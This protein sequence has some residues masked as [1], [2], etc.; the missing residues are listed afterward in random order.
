MSRKY[1][2]SSLTF[3]NLGLGLKYL[4]ID[5]ERKHTKS[6]PIG[7]KRFVKHAPKDH[8]QQREMIDLMCAIKSCLWPSW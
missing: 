3:P 6:F 5:A 8:R 1:L 2:H 4:P 7:K